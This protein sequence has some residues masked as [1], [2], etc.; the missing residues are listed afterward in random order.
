VQLRD[1]MSKDV[2][3]TTPDVTVA[4]AAKAM[5]DRGVGSACV[6][7]DGVLV[8][9]ITE[10]DVLRG[11]ASGKDLTEEPVSSW[12]TGNPDTIDVE[13]LPSEVSRR[14]QKA[15]YRHLPV[16]DDAGAL[17]GIASMRDVWRFSFLP[18]EPDDMTM[19][20]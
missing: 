19:R 2:L 8:G 16:V 5:T 3:T 9:I 15:G 4:G 14:L 17:V 6:M 18:D 11:A 13:E 12:M 10:R 20:T 7:A 1:V